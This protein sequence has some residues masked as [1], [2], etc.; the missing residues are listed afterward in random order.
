MAEL[1]ITDALDEDLLGEDISAERLPPEITDLKDR[2]EK[3]AE[4]HQQSQQ[5]DAVREQRK[6]K[7]PAQLPKT[8]PDARILPNKE[9]GFAANYTP[10]VTAETQGG[11]IVHCDVVIG[12]VEHEELLPMVSDVVAQFD[13]AVERVIADTAYTSGENLSGCE[14][15]NVELVGPLAEV[16]C[17]DNPADR[18]D[19]SEPVATEDHDRL[20]VNPKTKVLDKSAFVYDASSDCYHCPAGRKLPLYTTKMNCS[21]SGNPTLHHHVYRSRD[22]SG[23]PLISR[24]RKN[25]DAKKGREVIRDAHEG[26]RERH[27]ERMKSDAAQC[28]YKRRGHIGEVPF[29]V[30]K[31]G[32]EF[33]RFLLRGIERVQQEWRWASLAYNLKKLS[34]HWQQLRDD[35][36][37]SQPARTM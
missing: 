26:A 36:P 32:F 1:E 21:E 30:I 23:C 6:L 19:P 15:Q 16:A 4:L 2:R 5:I 22:C 8:D 11:L 18:A 3:L 27:R 24:C 31:S 14:E 12:N 9:G 28:Q 13:V 17:K 34:V 33:R 37:K 20:P 7:G 25:P 29:A 10:M 35:Q